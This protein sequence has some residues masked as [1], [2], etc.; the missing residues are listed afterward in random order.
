MT[1]NLR[2]S[3]ASLNFARLPLI[4]VASVFALS[5]C[6]TFPTDQS[7]AVAVAWDN[8]AA[9]QGCEYRGTVYGS[10]GHFYDFWLHADKD[11]VWGA[12]NQMRKKTAEQGGNLLYLYPPM[13]FTGSVTMMGNA[14]D[15]PSPLNIAPHILAADSTP[16]VAP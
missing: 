16:V 2:I 4:A 15:C 5:G 1:K 8:E 11:M 9:L 6:V 12:M 7:N 13:R 14:Y 3:V 10:E